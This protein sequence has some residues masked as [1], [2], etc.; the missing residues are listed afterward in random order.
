L[1]YG[2]SKT[3]LRIT[4][5]AVFSSLLMGLLV[6]QLEGLNLAFIIIISGSFYFAVL[7]LLR[8][9]EKDDIALVRHILKRV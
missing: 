3:N 5:K 8:G 6:I 1:T 9:F 7:Y 4:A 2:I